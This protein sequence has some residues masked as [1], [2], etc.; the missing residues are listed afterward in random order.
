MAIYV[1]Q[2]ALLHVY[3]TG[4]SKL[5]CVITGAMIRVCVFDE[6]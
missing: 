4:I 2:K 6:R 1:R 5:V 3:N